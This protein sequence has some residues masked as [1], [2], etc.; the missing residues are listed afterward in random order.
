M[1][2][3]RQDDP[4]LSRRSKRRQTPHV[5]PIETLPFEGA[6]VLDEVPGDLGAFLFQ[7]VRDILLWSSFAADDRAR[8]SLFHKRRV[9]IPK[10]KDLVEGQPLETDLQVLASVVVAPGS[11]EPD[12]LAGACARVSQWAVDKSLYQTAYWFAFAASS[13]L[14]LDPLMCV[15]SGRIA[16]KQAKYELGKQWFRRAV[17]L[18]RT[19]RRWNVLATALISWA[20]LELQRGNLPQARTRLMRAWRTARK[21]DLRHLAGRAQHDLL[22]LTIDTGEW[23][24]A[25]SHAAAALDLYGPRATNIPALAHDWAYL[26]LRRKYFSAALP[27][28]EAV[29]PYITVPNERILVLSSIARAAGA[30]GESKRFEDAAEGVFQLAGI[31]SEGTAAALISVAEGAYAIGDVTRSLE[32]AE[33]ALQLARGRDEKIAIEVAEELIERIRCAGP[34]EMNEAP[35][36]ENDIGGRSQELIRRIQPSAAHR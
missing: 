34:R 22:Q 32:Q 21:Y 5:P 17:R 13:I 9:T 7:R 15:A 8:S 19:S 16:R 36:A 20:T 10:I 11:C 29:L 27:V 14:P 18:S 2:G 23:D 31:T 35:P 33:R 25:E 1:T 4:V 12:E 3:L 26:W 28:F 30:R 6:R 24:A